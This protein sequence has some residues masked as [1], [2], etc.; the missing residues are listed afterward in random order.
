MNDSVVSIV[1]L[2][3][4]VADMNSLYREIYI[5]AYKY[6]PTKRMA[7]RVTRNHLAERARE[8]RIPNPVLKN[9]R[10]GEVSFLSDWVSDY[11]E[12]TPEE[13]GG[14]YFADAD[15]EEVYPIVVDGENH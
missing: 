14:K 12:L 11:N 15:L 3:E 13:W 1:R 8:W 5:D 9:T 10:T 2:A 4:A 6:C 7:L